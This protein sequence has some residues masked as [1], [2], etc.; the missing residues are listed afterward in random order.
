VVEDGTVP[1]GTCRA[2][3]TRL[4]TASG[5]TISVTDADARD[6]VTDSGPAEVLGSWH[7]D[8]HAASLLLVGGRTLADARRL[9]Q[10]AAADPPPPGAPCR[11]AGTRL[12]T[13]SGGTISVTA[14][15]ARDTVTDSGPAEVLGS[16]HLDIHAASLLLVGGRTLADARRLGLRADADPSAEA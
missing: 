15:D 12:A 5:G 9:G 2:A 14:A 7:L 6:T 13:A 3:G 11:A 16:C 8:I 4:V 1:E 10:R